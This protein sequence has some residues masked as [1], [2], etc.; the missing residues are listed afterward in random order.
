MTERRT[1]TGSAAAPG[2][3]LGVVHRTDRP[4][5]RT[6]LP[7]GGDPTQQITDAFDAVA[8][9][10]LALSASLREQGKD[11]QADIMEVNGYIAK[12]DP[13]DHPRSTHAVTTSSALAEDKWMNYI[14][15]QS[16]DV[17][18]AAVEAEIYP[19][20]VINAECIAQAVRTGL[21]AAVQARTGRFGGV[22][23]R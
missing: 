21:S 17:S 6:A 2:T 7:A 10:L 1:Y 16:S 8:A 14:V 9:R 20:P 22:G 18:L 13:Y 11:E 4:S 19:M 12:M 5:T 23:W 3:A 15:Q